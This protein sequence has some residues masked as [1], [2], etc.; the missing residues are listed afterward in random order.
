MAIITISRG[1][2]TGGKT[3]AE[4]L[5]ER[6]GYPCVS[7]EDVLNSA[8]M[9]YNI[10]EE[11]LTQVINNPPPFWVQVPAKRM[12]FL[13]C[14]T[15]VL[16][17]HVKEGNLIYHGHAGHL[18]F[19]GIPNI[20]RLR[21]IADMNYRMK[22]AKQLY[23]LEGQDAVAYIEKK[24][25][26]RKKWAKFFYGIDID[27][28]ILY[29]AVFNLEHSSIDKICELIV[30]MTDI[31]RY[32]VTE[33]SLKAIEDF[34]LASKAWANLAMDKQTR[35]ASVNIVADN[36]V[37]DIMGNVSSDKTK[38]AIIRVVKQVEGVREVKNNMGIGA[39]WYW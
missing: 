39:D 35:N 24:D 32:R 31:D 37:L 1:T 34:I 30:L 11:E 14:Y 27:D 19:R 3:L 2:F 33:E 26:K 6:L 12:A 10:S 5:G 8:K 15:A 36:G 18:L 29:D 23:N 22:A 9:D 17:E 16:L 38:E 4:C 21:L 7:R 13:K 25:K 20:M 28:P